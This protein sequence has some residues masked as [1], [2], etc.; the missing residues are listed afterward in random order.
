MSKISS[1][2]QTDVTLFQIMFTIPCLLKCEF[3]YNICYHNKAQGSLQLKSEMLSM[4]S[5]LRTWRR[6][7]SL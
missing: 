3:L 4:Y 1:T 5:R 6:H 7:G 2:K